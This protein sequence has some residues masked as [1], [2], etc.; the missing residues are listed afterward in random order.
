MDSMLA[1]KLQDLF[2]VFPRISETA[3]SEKEVSGIFSDAREVQPDSVFVAICGNV[4]DG[5]QFIVDA[6]KAG[7]I[8]LVVSDRSNV[9]SDFAGIV[10]EVPRTREILDILACRFYAYP[11]QEL[12]CAGVTGTNGKTSI[13][14]MIESILT[15]SEIPT[16]VIG[17]IDHH[18]GQ[19][20]WTSDMTTPDPVSL[21]MRLREFLDAGAKAVAMEVSSHALHQFRVDGVPFNTVIFTNLTRDHLDYH[22]NM[23]SYFQAKQRLFTDLMWRTSKRPAFAIVNVDDKFG[24]RLKIA[25]PVT[26]WTY[27]AKK[28]DFT[29]SVMKMDFT[30]TQFCL[31]TPFGEVEIHL[32]M[33]GTHNVMNATAAIATGMSVGIPLPVCA[34]AISLFSG[35]PGRL[36]L[37]PHR[38]NFTVFIDYAHTPD[39]LEN[40]LSALVSVRTNLKTKVKIWTVFGCGGDRDKGKRPLMAKVAEQFSDFVMITS[41]NPRSEDPRTIL[42]E[43]IE[44]I[45]ASAKEKVFVQVDRRKALEEVF[46]KASKGDVVVIAGKGHEDYQIIGTEKFPFSDYLVSQEILE[47]I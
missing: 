16:G 27:G 11:G 6:V 30:S 33:S 29:Y 8:A 18:L 38:Q 23:N 9:P 44:G 4:A 12:F 43:I 41:D 45:P 15:H 1:M 39:A 35:V 37:V 21:Q 13:T 20:I 3:F 40:T 26:V 2:A 25:D 19:K 34:L 22:K 46:A 10:L 5:H 47:S 14:Y 17:T 28:A 42:A 7:A 24:R 36:Q 32:P 31:R